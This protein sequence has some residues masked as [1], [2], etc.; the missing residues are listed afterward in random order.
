MPDRQ[1]DGTGR[2]QNRTR[3]DSTRRDERRDDG[4]GRDRTGHDDVRGQDGT[5]RTAG[6]TSHA[7][8]KLPPHLAPTWLPK[9]AIEHAVATAVAAAVAA[10]VSALA[11]ETRRA[12]GGEANA[13]A[14]T[15]EGEGKNDQNR[16]IKSRCP[17][18]TRMSMSARSEIEAALV[19]V[20]E[21]RLEAAA[22]K[23]AAEKTDSRRSHL[24]RF[25]FSQIRVEVD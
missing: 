18:K 12:A 20:Y 5:R 7:D 25:A 11:A 3:R 10:V 15:E 4:N 9:A 19:S 17:S 23:Q 24:R 8:T 2:G 13:E 21:K 14:E 6:R 1:Q 22:V 16:Q